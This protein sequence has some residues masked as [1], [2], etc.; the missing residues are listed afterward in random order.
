MLSLTALSL[1]Y[2]N[3]ISKNP[4]APT[5]G[6][7]KSVFKSPI[8]LNDTFTCCGASRAVETDRYK[9]R[10]GNLDQSQMFPP[11]SGLALQYVENSNNAKWFLDVFEELIGREIKASDFQKYIELD[12]TFKN[13]ETKVSLEDKLIKDSE[14]MQ[15]L[16]L[17]DIPK[18]DAA[19]K[20]KVALVTGGTAGIGAS[21]A[22]SLAVHGASKVYVVGREERWWDYTKINAVRNGNEPMQKSVGTEAE[23]RLALEALLP[24]ATT[25]EINAYITALRHPKYPQVP[26]YEDSFLLPQDYPPGHTTWYGIDPNK[27]ANIEF[28]RTDVRNQT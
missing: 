15:R 5:C 11:L 3:S 12:G 6:A 8:S 4:P 14:R 18:M 13:G 21:L 22:I 28:H 23:C 27:L 24:S 1:G 19:F 26:G 7:M 20:N 25:A 10:L 17:L 9:L 16:G 2:A